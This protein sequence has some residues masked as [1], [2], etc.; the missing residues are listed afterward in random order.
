PDEELEARIRTIFQSGSP[1]QFI[2]DHYQKFLQDVLAMG[3]LE[4][5]PP[6]TIEELSETLEGHFMETSVMNVILDLIDDDPMS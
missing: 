2:P 4:E 6:A 5:I 3:Q 1:G